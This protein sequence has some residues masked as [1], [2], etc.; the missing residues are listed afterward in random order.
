M[1]TTMRAVGW[2]AIVILLTLAGCHGRL[3]EH[4]DQKYDVSVSYPGNL[5]LF[6]DKKVLAEHL[7]SSNGETVDRPEVLFVLTTPEQAKLSCSVHHLP[8]EY[9]LTADQYFEA[10]TA[11]ELVRLKVNIVEPKSEVE[12]AGKPFLRVG[13]TLRTGE[14]VLR[15]QIFQYLDVETGRILVVTITAPAQIWEQEL[16]VLRPVLDSIKFSWSSKAVTT[17]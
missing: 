11:Q 4:V 13:F 8:K 15:S 3:F 14:L 17:P 12:I 6:Q 2:C 10:S 7:G 1:G 16:E 9:G 5:D